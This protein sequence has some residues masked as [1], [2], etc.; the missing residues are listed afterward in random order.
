MVKR[1]LIN[2]LLDVGPKIGKSIVNA[3][4]KVVNSGGGGA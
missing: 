4:A 2:L 1:L 3:Y